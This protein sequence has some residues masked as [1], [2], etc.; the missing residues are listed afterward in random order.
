VRRRPR[1]QLVAQLMPGA[2][3]YLRIECGTWSTA[4]PVSCSLADLWDVLEHKALSARRV[5]SEGHLRVP[6]SKW[7]ELTGT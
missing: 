2:E 7:R 5:T 4:L 6:V 1:H 3:P